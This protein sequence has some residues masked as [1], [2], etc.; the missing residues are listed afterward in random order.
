MNKFDHMRRSTIDRHHPKFCA[1]SGCK[2]QIPTAHY[3][4]E[5]HWRQIPK[6]LRDRI[7]AAYQIG[8]EA[9]VALVSEEYVEA[10]RA[11]Q[12]WIESLTQAQAPL[13]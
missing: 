5:A 2:A 4:C 9:D 13:A 1:W 8:Q 7:W 10:H 3:A 11:V 6:S 12:R